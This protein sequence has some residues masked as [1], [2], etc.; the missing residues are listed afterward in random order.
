MK[1][2]NMDKFDREKWNMPRWTKYTPSLI[3]GVFI[4]FLVGWVFAIPAA[5]AAF[6]VYGLVV[7]RKDIKNR[8]TVVMKPNA[9]MK[10][11]ARREEEL[12]R[13]KER[14]IYENHI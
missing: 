9:A 13:D 1:K 10:A 14:I 12:K 7:Y 5:I 3:A 4:A 8:I 6:L 11:V 2:N